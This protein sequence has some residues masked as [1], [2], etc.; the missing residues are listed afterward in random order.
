[1]SP[2]REAPSF[3]CE[4]PSSFLS[5]PVFCSSF[6]LS[7]GRRVR[8]SCPLHPIRCCCLCGRRSRAESSCAVGSSVRPSVLQLLPSGQFGRGWMD[9]RTLARSLCGITFLWVR[10]RASRL[11]AGRWKARRRAIP[12]VGGMALHAVLLCESIDVH[13]FIKIK[14]YACSRSSIISSS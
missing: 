6:S 2:S 8:P 10:G 1:M 12:S 9:A 3:L 7:V 11:A 4:K 14:S 5:S 13:F